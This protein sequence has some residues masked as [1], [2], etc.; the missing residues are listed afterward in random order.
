MLRNI[1]QI[2]QFSFLHLLLVFLEARDEGVISYLFPLSRSRLWEPQ[3]FYRPVTTLGY[4][5]LKTVTKQL[6]IQ[7]IYTI[8]SPPNQTLLKSPVY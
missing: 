6:C 5:V 3:Y 8:K 4:F 1:L 2:Q 7:Y